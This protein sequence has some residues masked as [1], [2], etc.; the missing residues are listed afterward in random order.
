MVIEILVLLDIVSSNR[1]IWQWACCACW[2]ECATR[3]TRLVFCFPTPSSSTRLQTT[4]DTTMRKRTVRT[5][6]CH[7]NTTFS[8]KST[9]KK[10]KTKTTSA[11]PP[12]P[13]PPPPTSSFKYLELC[14]SVNWFRL[15]GRLADRLSLLLDH[16]SHSSQTVRRSPR[17]RRYC[18]ETNWATI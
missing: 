6:A 5:S 11:P 9:A 8:P 14:A 12:P 17:S 10:K 4:P 13:P 3:T 7:Y 16:W 1:E 15:W 18:V 2:R